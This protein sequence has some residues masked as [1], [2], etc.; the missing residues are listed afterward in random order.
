M[1]SKY[2]YIASIT[3][4]AAVVV[5]ALLLARL[6]PDR[7]IDVDAQ[8]P[9]LLE[10]WTGDGSERDPG[11]PGR[12]RGIADGA[13]TGNK[14]KVGAGGMPNLKF[15]AKSMLDRLHANE[16]KAAAAA[17]AAEKEAAKAAKAE[18]LDDKTSDTPTKVE[19]VS[20]A[21]WKKAHPGQKVPATTGGKVIVTGSKTGANSGKTGGTSIATGKVGTGKGSGEDGFG[22]PGGKGKNGG[23]G[24]SGNALK[25]FTGDVRGKFQSAYA[26][27]FDDKGGELD[28]N[29]DSGKVILAVSPSGLVRFHG[30]A[31]RPADPLLESIVKEAI[32]K[33]PPVRTPPSGEEELVQFEVSGRVNE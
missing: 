13:V 26:P 31:R 4:H 12:D 8:D 3:V 27:I 9:L 7:V 19:K 30:W 17:A 14:A 22:R 33:M 23:D 24:G 21:D 6:A 2:G 29:R 15:S 5:L 1:S 25:L 10:V 11:I 32:A 18:K 28:S 16:A 20:I